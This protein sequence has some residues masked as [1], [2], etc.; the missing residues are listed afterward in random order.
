[1]TSSLGLLAL[2]NYAFPTGHLLFDVSYFVSTKKQ[3]LT[4]VTARASSCSSEAFWH[5]CSVKAQ[6]INDL[7]VCCEAIPPRIYLPRLSHPWPVLR[8]L[9]IKASCWVELTFLRRCTRSD[10]GLQQF[11]TWGNLP[12][13]WHVAI[14]RYTIGCHSGC[15]APETH[16]AANCPLMSRKD[17]GKEKSSLKYW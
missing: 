17:P 11:L 5:M 16:V 10:Q 9:I 3:H 6:S 1:M 13:G 14:S 15:L 7:R 4:F 2:S 12:Y 8:S